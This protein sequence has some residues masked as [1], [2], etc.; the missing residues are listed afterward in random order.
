MPLVCFNTNTFK[1]ELVDCSLAATRRAEF[2]YRLLNLQKMGLTNEEIAASIR[3]DHL[4][5]LYA[6]NRA[7]I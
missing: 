1:G 5:A 3:H 7:E 6:K 4:I 2:N